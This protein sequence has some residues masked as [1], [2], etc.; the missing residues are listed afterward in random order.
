MLQTA[1]VSAV[2]AAVHTV[3]KATGDFKSVQECVDGAAEGDTC[4]VGTGVWKES[5]RSSKGVRIEGSGPDQTKFDGTEAVPDNWKVWKGDIYVQDLP[6][7]LHFDTQQLFVDESFISEARWPN[8]NLED[9]LD[10]SKAWKEAAKGTRYGQIYDPDLNKT[11]IDW[12]GAIATLN[13]DKRIFTYTRT[14]LDYNASAGTFNYTL[15]LPN[16]KPRAIGAYV[17][18]RYFLSGILAALDAPGEWFLD[19]KEWKLYVWTPDSKPPGTRVSMKMRDLC[20]YGSQKTGPLEVASSSFFGCTFTM[21]NCTG[22][23]ATDLVLTYPSYTRRIEFLEIPSGPMPNITMMHGD[24]NTLRKISLKYSNHGGILVIGSRNLIEDVLIVSTDWLGTLDFPP[25]QIGFG[26]SNCGNGIDDSPTNE[27]A[28]YRTDLK[29]C[30]HWLG[31]TPDKLT[32]VMGTDNVITRVTVTDFG[33]S[34][35]VTSQLSCEVSYAHVSKGGMI[36]CD[37]AGIHA[38][39]LPTP[40]MY[41][42]S[43]SNCTKSFHHNIVHDCRE[44]CMRGDDASLNI[45]MNNNIMYNCGNPLRDPICGDASAGLILKGDYHLV[46]DLTIFNVST[47]RGQGEFVPFTTYGPPPP[48]CGNP[49]RGP[50]VPQNIHSTFFNIVANVVDTKG[51]PPLNKTAVF[52]DAILQVQLPAMQLEDPENGNFAPKP[53]SPMYMKG[54]SHGSVKSKNIG[55]I[56]PDEPAWKAGCLSFP[57][58]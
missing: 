34:G 43:A 26:P 5:V 41:N 18:S 27:I 37:H 28:P 14:V 23:S 42:R 51:G 48:S 39:N 31:G 10:V 25:L 12:N 3:D 36:G 47:E 30:G 52:T 6:E 55:A 44:K 57:E 4:K 32:M 49:G 53:T 50:C 21:Q 2:L 56:Q 15:P 8:A 19:T 9:M 45:T 46:Y 54:I 17:G 11:G 13:S 22:C 24:D 7:P 33:N 40:C 20:F 35:I 58:C 29:H 38:D 1:F 16:E